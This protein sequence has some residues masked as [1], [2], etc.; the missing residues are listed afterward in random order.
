MR[1]SCFA[2]MLVCS[3]VALAQS[4]VKPASALDDLPPLNLESVPVGDP[5]LPNGTT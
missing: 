4:P 3:S 1:G 2:W 5:M